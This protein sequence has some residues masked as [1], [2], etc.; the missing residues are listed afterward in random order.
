M[1]DAKIAD[2]G[3]IDEVDD[4]ITPRTQATK[5]KL[6]SKLQLAESVN[7]YE[8]IVSQLEQ[9]ISDQVS[10]LCGLDLPQTV[11]WLDGRTRDCC[12]LTCAT[13]LVN[14]EFSNIT[15]QD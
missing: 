5:Q 2:S 10:S 8:A 15:S 13:Q 7:K 12:L 3:L 6:D 14:V 11:V 9:N 1:L 4:K